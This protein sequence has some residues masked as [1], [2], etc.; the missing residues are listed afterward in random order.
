MRIA[1]LAIA[2]SPHTIDPVFIKITSHNIPYNLNMEIQ[3]IIDKCEN[4]QY[5]AIAVCMGLCGNAMIGIRSRT[6]PLVIPRAHDCCTILLGSCDKFLKYFSHRLSTSWTS[7]C[8]KE[9]KQIDDEFSMLVDKYGK[10]DALYIWNTMYKAGESDN[11]IIYITCPEIEDEAHIDKVI[12]DAAQK[13]KSI[14]LLEG[15]SRLIFNLINGE[16]NNDEFLIVNPGEEITA[17]YDY[18]KVFETKT[19]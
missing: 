18:K 12:L 16:W 2:R 3:K 15:D 7:I 9:R 13:G 10:E 1:C 4:Q 19:Y 8:Y 17:V 11:K 14:E 5:D 6:I